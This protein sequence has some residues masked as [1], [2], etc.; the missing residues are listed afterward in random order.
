MPWG[1]GANIGYSLQATWMIPLIEQPI[2]TNCQIEPIIKSVQARPAKVEP[3]V[4]I[5]PIMVIILS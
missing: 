4:P 5:L 3:Q 2:M 1:N